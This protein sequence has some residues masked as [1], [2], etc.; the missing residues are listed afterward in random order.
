LPKINVMTGSDLVMTGSDLVMTGPDLV[1]TGLDLV[2]TGLDLSIR[3]INNEDTRR[4]ARG[5]FFRDALGSRTDTS[6]A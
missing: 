5:G 3:T 6:H 1:M 2:M 4:Y